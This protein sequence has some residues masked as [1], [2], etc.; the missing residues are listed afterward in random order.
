MP[1]PGAALA[2]MEPPGYGRKHLSSARRSSATAR[3]Q[4]SRPVMGGNTRAGAD[5]GKRTGPGRNGA[6]RL[7]AETPAMAGAAARNSAMPQWSRPVMGGNT[8]PAVQGTRPAVQGRNGAAR[9]WA[10]TPPPGGHLEA[11]SQGRNGAARLWAETPGLRGAAG[12]GGG[13]A[14]E[15]P[16]Y[17]RKHRPRDAPPEGRYRAAMEPP[18][19][20]RKHDH[21]TPQ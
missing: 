18:G 7:W 8:R 15:P 21:A 2:A 16:G 4:W 20:G 17:G 11:G 3:P 19:Y 5:A 13:A 14:M 9:L 12:G 10:E 6:A 1:G